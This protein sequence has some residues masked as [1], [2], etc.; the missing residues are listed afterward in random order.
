[1]P[2]RFFW[3]FLLLYGYSLKAQQ[4]T[5]K[6][7]EASLVLLQQE[8]KKNTF[9]GREIY[10]HDSLQKIWKTVLQDAA[11][12]SWPFS[13]VAQT[14]I[15]ISPDHTFRL[16][17]WNFYDH[18]GKCHYRLLLQ[19]KPGPSG[20]CRVTIFRHSA[21]ALKVNSSET[22][23]YL[24]RCWYGALYYTIIPCT[25]AHRVYYLLLGFIP[26]DDFS[27][28]KVIE[29]MY[30]DEEGNP[31]LGMPVISILNKSFCRMIFEYN[32]RV[33]MLLQYEPSTGMIVFDHLAPPSPSYVGTYCFYGP[34]GTYDALAF[35]GTSWNVIPKVERRNPKEGKR[36]PDFTTGK[37]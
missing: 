35:N 21:E 18:K 17:T 1:M 8:I 20:K 32:E 6:K 11:S 12:F 36:N 15:I 10:L 19:Q 5:L 33:S 28:Q 30:F 26:K 16:I 23:K 34:D 25:T 24:P 4:E 29:T 9:P 7:A 2:G 3:C 31:V 27:N 13:S 22:V 14:G 37:K